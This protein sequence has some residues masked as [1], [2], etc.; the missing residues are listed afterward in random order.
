MLKIDFCQLA[1]GN[2]IATDHFKLIEPN[3]REQIISSLSNN[4]TWWED[5]DPEGAVAETSNYVYFSSA[6][7]TNKVLPSNSTISGVSIGVNNIHLPN[8]YGTNYGKL[9]FVIADNPA[10]VDGRWYTAELTQYIQG[11]FNDGLGFV[12]GVLSLEGF[13]TNVFKYCAFGV[14]VA[15]D[16]DDSVYRNKA[17]F[18][19]NSVIVTYDLPEA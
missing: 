3:A 16:I 12:N 4:Y 9:F 2:Q 10:I 6:L 18:G 1:Q 15:L 7:T 13:A 19:A 11:N 17:S 8:P 14:G 5:V